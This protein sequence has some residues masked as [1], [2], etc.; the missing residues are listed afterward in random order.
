MLRM[1]PAT[2][3]M[4][5]DELVPEAPTG[6]V[7]QQLEAPLSPAMPPPGLPLPVVPPVEAP[8][9]SA[10]AGAAP[11]V[12]TPSEPEPAPEPE[13]PP[14]PVPEPLQLPEPMP[15]AQAAPEDPLPPPPTGDELMQPEPE[16]ITE[17]PFR[18]GDTLQEVAEKRDQ[19]TQEAIDAKRAEAAAR[20]EEAQIKADDAKRRR[21]FKEQYQKDLADVTRRG[22]E[23]FARR[24]GIEQQEYDRARAL[25]EKDVWGDNS[26]MNK[27]LAGI[28]MLLGGRPAAGF[29]IGAV[30]KLE[31]NKKQA[32]ED[33]FKR[34]D[35][36]GKDADKAR[37]KLSEDIQRL[38]TTSAAGLE[39]AAAR[40]DAELAAQGVP[41]AE[42]EK[43]KEILALKQAALDARQRG[44]IEA[45]KE[46]EARLKA[47]RQ[48]L[49]DESEI[50]LNK[51]RIADLQARAG[52]SKAKTGKI[53]AGGAGTGRRTATGMD[54]TEAMAALES[55]SEKN[56]G[57]NAGLWLKA[58][59]LGLKDPGKA[60]EGVVKRSKGAEYQ[61]KDAQF[62]ASAIRA[63]DEIEQSGYRPT[64]AVIQKWI[65][66]QREIEMAQKLGTSDT[67]GQILTASRQGG[68][69]SKVP[70]LSLA[71]SEV[72]GIPDDAQEY[73]A[74][75]RR[76]M[77][78]IA[79]KQS[80]AAISAT[81]WTNFFN[82]YGPNSKGGLEAA[83]KYSQDLFKLG[84]APSRQL[85]ATGNVPGQ[86]S[87]AP[88][89]QEPSFT[90]VTQRN[91]K[92]GATRR[93]KRYADGREEVMP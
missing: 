31:E 49:K 48:R 81:E 53:G 56:P 47:E 29:I 12:V 45:H 5:D 21:E 72:D 24:R 32:V 43:N 68:I 36:A 92:T 66:N 69:L 64:K 19:V 52:L 62:G 59:E 75:A 86:G 27:V 2:G 74:R 10:A 51:A 11:G 65:N 85:A 18:A 82:Q 79:R 44:L 23:E 8:I 87:A 41:A 3:L 55:Y 46:S 78:S 6:L 42:R 57:D 60:V 76:Y 88:G 71:Q 22:E 67:T 90:I 58:G 93:V 20:A 50:E 25:G 37:L 38:A 70:G 77:E 73:F 33:A 9:T 63:I 15:G 83:R 26:T 17:E 89:K 13:A 40:A 14:M 16:S 35:H 39:A 34:A 61:T 84:G 4:E 28:A 7:G 30:S 1:N 54:E 80:G 91:A